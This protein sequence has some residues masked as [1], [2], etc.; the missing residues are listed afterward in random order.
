MKIKSQM[1]LNLKLFKKL[2]QNLCF[3]YNNLMKR[4]LLKIAYNGSKFHGWQR[5][6]GQRTVQGEIENAIFVAFKQ[7]CD[8][9]GQMLVF[10]PLLNR[11]ILILKIVCQ[12]IKLKLF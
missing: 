2:A 4:I 8:V 10:M 11:H 5:Q 3:L 9:F 1:K 6:E 7:R 12:L